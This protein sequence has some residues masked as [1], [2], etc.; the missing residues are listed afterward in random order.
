[1]KLII[2]RFKHTE[3]VGNDYVNQTS[4]VN[5]SSTDLTFLWAETGIAVK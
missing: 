1:M 3:T 4:F 5:T 2:I